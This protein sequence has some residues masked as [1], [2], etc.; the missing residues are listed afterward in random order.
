MAKIHTKAKRMK[1][2]RSTTIKHRYFFTRVVGKKGAKS[3]VSKE[4]A[5]QWAQEQ[6]LDKS[7]YVLHELQNGKKF[8]WRETPRV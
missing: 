2:I 5:Q 4:A 7:A 8:Q 6:G 3:F 1:K